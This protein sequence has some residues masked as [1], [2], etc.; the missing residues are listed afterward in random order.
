MPKGSR[1]VTAIG[2]SKSGRYVAASDA[3]EKIT[4]HLFDLNK[5]G[6][7]SSSECTINM[8]VV[9][10]A[11][12]PTEE[13]ML[14]TAGEKHCVTYEVEKGDIKK[15]QTN[16]STNF[17]SVGWL[18]DDKFKG[19]MIAGGSDGKLYHLRGKTE[20]GKTFSNSKGSVHSVA[21]RNEG[22]AEYVFAG[23][24][25]KTITCYL[26]KDKLTAKD[27]IWSIDT[28]SPPRSID[29][30][31]G[32]IL[33]GYK[34]GSISEVPFTKDGKGAPNVVM[35]SHCDG[36]SWGLDVIN[37]D[38]GSIRAVTTADDNRILSYNVKT[39]ESL[40]EGEVDKPPKKKKK[41][42][43]GYRGGASSMSSQ[44]SNCQ[45]RA[46][47]WNPKLKHLAVASNV[48]E[49]TIREVNW[50]EVD[51]RKEGSLNNIIHTLFEDKSK[52]KK[53]KY[54]WIEAMAYSPDGNYLAV[55]SHDNFIYILNAKKG[56]KPAFKKGGGKMTGH[57]S[58]ITALDW[59][60]SSECMRSTC[61]A[62]ELLFW[63]PKEGKRD[64]S[65]VK[66]MRNTDWVDHAAKL[67][68]CVEGITP[69][70]CDG[71]H[72]NS[73]TYSQDHSLIA[74]GDDYGLVQVFLNP[75][76]AN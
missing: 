15:S 51:A 1:L 12:C 73:C 14:A 2:F 66:T 37:L 13:A 38:D 6:M 71:T 41:A 18:N 62:H 69:S 10:L 46:C 11:W 75:A 42:K 3:A 9:H 40:A 43:G 25:D 44:P 57:S 16:T 36:E 22:G 21:C 54:E 53:K 48:G 59:D 76:R 26:L 29:M 34:N 17:C 64:P 8:K 65:G 32:I 47:A 4:V 49:V 56:Y 63:N 27:K 52:D 39:H 33:L 61:G 55:G 67:G 5:D 28:D 58:F 23:G 7:K 24:N 20:V 19:Q 72:I 70:G 60:M 50:D 31:N 35:T 68:W 30:L 74:T 45:S